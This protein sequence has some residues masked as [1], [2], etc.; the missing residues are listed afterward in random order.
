MQKLKSSDDIPLMKQFVD[1]IAPSGPI[2]QR[3]DDLDEDFENLSTSGFEYFNAT[4]ID[5]GS[6]VHYNENFILILCYGILIQF[7]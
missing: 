6:A 3:I 7:F 1:M 5:E 2:Y 4:V